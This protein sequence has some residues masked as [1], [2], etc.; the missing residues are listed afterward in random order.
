MEEKDIDITSLD[1]PN[2]EL[3]E[4]QETDFEDIEPTLPLDETEPLVENLSD[5][6]PTVS[7]TLNDNDEEEIVFND[8]QT[9][10][11]IEVLDNVRENIRDKESDSQ[12]DVVFAEAEERKTKAP[13]YTIADDKP[14]LPVKGIIAA[15]VGIIGI[16]VIASLLSKCGNSSVQ[17]VA[18]VT[19]NDQTAHL[20]IPT[21]DMAYEI[22]NVD[23]SNIKFGDNVTVEGVSLSGKTLSQAYSIMQDK[24]KEI[25]DDIDITIN[26]DKKTVKITED[27]FSFDTDISDVLIQAYHYSRGELD[28]PTVEIVDNN[29][30]TDFKVT[31]V[32]NNN[33]VNNAVKKASNKFD[34]Q[35]QDA[36]VTQFD[37]D[38]SEKFTYADGKDGYL[39]NQNDLKQKIL[40][41]LEQPDKKANFSIKTV[42]TAYKVHL[43]E[44]KANTK[45]IASH[46]TTVNNRWE[47]NANMELA[48]RAASGTIV[49]PGETFSFNE[50]TGDTTVG[51]EHHYANGTVGSY[52]KSTAI[53]R[54]E[55]VDQY[56]GGICQA[57]TTI[58]N[59]ALKADMEILERH[60]HQFPSFYADL[61]LDATVDYGNLDM[62]FKNNKA[63]PIYIA[64]YVY[65]SNGDGLNELNVEMY[66]PLDTSY[67]EIVPVGWVTSAG[68][69]TYSA[70][71]A[72]VYFK[73]GEEINRVFLPEGSYD[74][75]SDGVYDVT[76]QSYAQSLVADDPG[77][78]PA[79]T[80][81]GESPA[82]YSP[83]G[84]GD[85]EPIPYGTAAEYLKEHVK[86]N[87]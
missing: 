36:Q 49:K 23:T 2:G 10:K 38:S 39:I 68:T 42:K 24:L 5:L 22:K 32:I 1:E 15:A 53:L 21:G 70:M 7:E 84:C 37:P 41:I 43:D 66:G 78:G 26:C 31:S 54:G 34:V 69:E 75:Y 56:G 13:S 81:T 18:E 83:N 30:K 71:G 86:S 6:E 55:H 27:D 40:E 76:T 64:T 67:D 33:S 52:V 77:F 57:S 9:T 3:Y 60:S 62:R 72:K 58:Y 4:S 19:D 63:F 12:D 45:L 11:N 46:R 73:N 59:C 25:R 8:D 65:D 44:V 14:Q 80:P 74:Y 29:G 35:P 20:T 28:S 79:A 82:V 85:S 87:S 51:D 17:T 47:S 16:V 61:G 50:M 48:I